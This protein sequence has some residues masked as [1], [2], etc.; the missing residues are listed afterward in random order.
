M[1]NLKE[2]CRTKTE[3]TYNPREPVTVAPKAGYAG[4]YVFR[5]ERQSTAEPRTKKHVYTVVLRLEAAARSAPVVLKD[6]GGGVVVDV[7]ETST[8]EDVKAAIIERLKQ[9]SPSD[10]M[11]PVSIKD[12]P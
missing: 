3:F 1:D 11:P 7:L 9:D 4:C 5:H 2:K 10:S 12:Y 8:I 6:D